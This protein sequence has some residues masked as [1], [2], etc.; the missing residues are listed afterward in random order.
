MAK[1]N[2]PDIYEPDL[3]YSRGDNWVG[4]DEITKYTKTYYLGD[5]SDFVAQELGV[6]TAQN[7]V[8]I[9]K[10]LGTIDISVTDAF[11]DAVNGLTS[12]TIAADE[13]AIF[14]GEFAENGKLLNTKFVYKLQT[15]K[16]TYGVG[17]TQL[18][19]DDL[20]LLNPKQPETERNTLVVNTI[21]EE[22]KILSGYISR[23]EGTLVFD[24][25]PF[26]FTLSG[27][28]HLT[29]YS[30]SGPSIT[31]LTLA[32]ADATFGRFDVFALD[33]NGIKIIT[34]TPSAS[35]QIPFIEYGSELFY[36]SVFIPANATEPQI[37]PGTDFT[38][39]LITDETDSE[40]NEWNLINTPTNVDTNDTVTTPYKN[41]KSINFASDASGLLTHRK[42]TL[43]TY[44]TNGYLQF[45]LKL[46]QPLSEGNLGGSN[47]N[48]S[49]IKVTL[50]NSITPTQRP[51]NLF[52]TAK[53]NTIG[54]TP[55]DNS[56]T[57][58]QA[59]NIPMARFQYLINNVP[60]QFDTFSLE[61]I[62]C[63]Q[64]NID[65]VKMQVGIDNPTST[66]SQISIRDENDVEQFIT[67]DFI[68]FEG[69][70]FDSANKKITITGGVGALE[71]ATST[72]T[73]VGGDLIAVLG[74]Y[75]DSE[76]GVKL[77][78][79]DAAETIT[80]SHEL[81][82]SEGI[83]TN[84]IQVQTASSLIVSSGASFLLNNGVNQAAFLRNNIS[85]NRTYEMPNANGTFPLSVN[86]NT[87]D[88]AGNITIATGG[89]TMATTTF[90][91]YNTI[92]STD[93]QAAVE[94]L[95]DE[96][97]AAIIG[98][99]AGVSP[100][101]RTTVGGE[102]TWTPIP[103][104]NITNTHQ[105]FANGVKLVEGV[106]YTVS[107]DTITFDASYLPIGVEEQEYYPH[108]SVVGTVADDSIST[109]KIQDD[110]VT[111]DKL[112]NTAVTAGA[113][114]N[115]DITVDAQGRVTSAA[116]GSGGTIVYKTATITITDPDMSGGAV[117]QEIVNV[118]EGGTD[119]II[120]LD[121]VFFHASGFSGS[122]GNQNLTIY[123]SSETTD[124]IT[125]SRIFLYSAGT[126]MA[127]KFEAINLNPFNA[128]EGENQGL[129]VRLTSANL[130]NLTGDLK[131]TVV[132]TV[133]DLIP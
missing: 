58:W 81:V 54:L 124:L 131:V 67:N 62:R 15:G 49:I 132:Y 101:S 108:V 31:T 109:A 102:T 106:D 68:Q 74:D 10:Q 76:N 115:A 22:D 107:T 60:A 70:A 18:T 120:M 14:T 77:T 127:G 122:T 8:I 69:V 126:N 116:N 129:K 88:A 51:S 84:G 110:A 80:A 40:P 16:G 50:S 61:M 34:G 75:D 23:R 78:I 26:I 97:D 28:T 25:T 73:R 99:G 4:S 93:G 96:L 44:D 29:G 114:T 128:V 33:V 5:V 65:D 24:A 48:L 41:A 52:L 32:D 46:S 125:A 38:I 20:V 53:N 7:N 111:A 105:L 47:P 63:G 95:K 119:K 66:T 21:V 104:T 82:A 57:D 1:I 98:N 89:G 56:S 87:P 13:I 2:K 17:G 130:D 55:F 121:K 71:W 27:T 79:N 9:E 36:G 59:I 6:G 86:G 100:T 64:L 91:P 3:N 83:T 117:E 43:V 94:E 11:I 103:A 113:Y 39:D 12:Y 90:T 118:S 112:S 37:E 42:D 92:T 123:H 35:P 85:E 19:I 133:F 30:S 72:G 45:G